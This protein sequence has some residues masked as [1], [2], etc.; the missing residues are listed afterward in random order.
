MVVYQRDRAVRWPGYWDFPGGGRE[1]SECPFGCLAREVYEEFGLEI[2]REHIQSETQVASMVHPA[3]TAWFYVLC[4][5]DGA[6]KAIVFGNE[7]QR[8]ALMAPRDVANMPN[9]VPALQARRALWLQ[10]SGR[11][12]IY[13]ADKNIT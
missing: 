13:E 7:G 9:L 4:L 8:W 6:E 3:K 12:P 2:S 1:G 5:P 10:E 11:V